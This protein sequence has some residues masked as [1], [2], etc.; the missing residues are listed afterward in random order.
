M[1]RQR[2]T[3]LRQQLKGRATE[4]ES[5]VGNEENEG[6]LPTGFYKLSF[7]TLKEKREEK[8]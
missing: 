4:D 3:K 5:G 7:L 6:T 8:P 1:K 2:W